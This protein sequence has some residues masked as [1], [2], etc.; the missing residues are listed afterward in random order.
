MLVGVL[1]SE[2]QPIS[3]A[4]GEGNSIKNM[5]A[6]KKILALV[7]VVTILAGMLSCKAGQGCNCPKFSMK[8]NNIL[9]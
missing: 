2:T 5:K 3:S 7:A 4:W 8:T 6:I 1:I 9:K